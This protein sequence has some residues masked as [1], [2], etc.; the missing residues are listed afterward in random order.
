[1][2]TLHS[3]IGPLGYDCHVHLFD[4]HD[5]VT[6]YEAFG[7]GFPDIS[8]RTESSLYTKDA[9]IDMYEKNIWKFPG[10]TILAS[11]LEPETAIEVLER[12]NL[13]GFGELKCY[14][15][16]KINGVVHK[17]PYKSKEYW[18]PL[19]KYADT[20]KLPIWIHWSLL[21]EDDYYD[22]QDILLSYPKAKFII[23]HCGID[24]DDKIREA[25]T[26]AVQC[27]ERCL[28]LVEKHPNAY[29]DVS[30]TA[31]EF[32]LNNPQY[33]LPEGK[34]VIGSDINPHDYSKHP[35]E[36]NKNLSNY[37]KIKPIMA[38]TNI[39]KLI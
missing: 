28:K 31:T 6:P 24:T 29:C 22:L 21:R 11:A 32:I 3:F 5:C 13:K 7:V 17:L 20:H 8:V 12:F 37:K 18:G 33:H 16:A 1:M 38:N 25:N 30:W 35:E 39:L 4:I 9:V 27:F 23:C 19:F 15:T 26:T 36:F 2:K 34:Y 14:P 10:Y